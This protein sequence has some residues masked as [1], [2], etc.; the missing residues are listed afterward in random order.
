VVKRRLLTLVALAGAA[1]S[2]LGDRAG[3]PPRPGAPLPAFGAP[4][5]A[6]V[7]AAQGDTVF[8]SSYRGSPVVV[9]LW[10]TWCAP[11]RRETPHLQ[12]TWE[13]FRGQGLKMV[14]ITVDTRSAR[15]PALDFLEEMGVTYDQLHD[16]SQVVLDVFQVLGLPSTYVADA[17]GIIRFARI[18]PVF[19]GDAEFEAVLRELLAE[20][21]ASEPVAGEPLDDSG[22]GRP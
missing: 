15:E 19:E 7:G 4:P 14:G 17:E 16:P 20:A 6:P 5:L 8:L 13:R 11:C 9:N 3:G 12:D 1:C 21:E 22:G 2:P 10:A 18:G